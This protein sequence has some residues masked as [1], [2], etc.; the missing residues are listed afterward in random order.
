MRSLLIL[1]IFLIVGS[2][3]ASEKA[4]WIRISSVDAANKNIEVCNYQLTHCSPLGKKKIYSIKEIDSRRKT[5]RKLRNRT[6]AVQYVMAVLTIVASPV[7]LGTSLMNGAQF[8]RGTPYHAYI[9][10]LEYVTQ[11]EEAYE[12]EAL[13]SAQ[14]LVESDQALKVLRAALDA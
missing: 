8:F 10:A 5:I 7:T 12:V 6:V 11:I 3:G 13:G 4:R 9:V 14:I 1:S 2:A